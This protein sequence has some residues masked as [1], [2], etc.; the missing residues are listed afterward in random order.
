MKLLLNLNALFLLVPS[1][2]AMEVHGNDKVYLYSLQPWRVAKLKGFTT[3]NQFVSALDYSTPPVK[4]V[5][6]PHHL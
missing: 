5:P 6:Q 3:S 2:V 1:G 4:L